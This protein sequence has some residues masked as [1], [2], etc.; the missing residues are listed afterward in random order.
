MVIWMSMT[1]VT[2]VLFHQQQS[3]LVNWWFLKPHRNEMIFIGF[4]LKFLL[5]IKFDEILTKII[6]KPVNCKFLLIFL[7]ISL[8]QFKASI[9]LSKFK[10]NC[11]LSFYCSNILTFHSSLSPSPSIYISLSPSISLSL[12]GFYIRF[13]RIISVYGEKYLD[14]M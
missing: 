8:E 2:Y 4:L 1:L 5:H 13:P 9:N 11:H 6:M 14:C 12:K 10:L 7:G 3:I